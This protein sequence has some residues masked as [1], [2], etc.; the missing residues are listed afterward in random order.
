MKRLILFT[1]LAAA[2]INMMAQDDL[3]FNPKDEPKSEVTECPEGHAPDGVRPVDPWRGGCPRDV[4][5]YNRRGQL[6]SY[7]QKIGTDSLGNDIIQFQAGDGL[8][9]EYTS[10]ADTIYAGSAVYAGDDDYAYSRHMSRWDDWYGPY[11]IYYASRWGW[12]WPYRYGWYGWYDPWY[13]DLYWGWGGYYGW[14]DPWFY[15]YRPYWGYGWGYPG[16]GGHYHH[17]GMAGT[18]NHGIPSRRGTTNTFGNFGGRRSAGS[19]TAGVN[20]VNR[21]GGRTGTQTNGTFGGQR[22]STTTQPS[23]TYTPSRSTSTFGGTRSS[24]SFGGS[25]G[26]SF[27][28]GSRGGGFGGGGSRGGGGSFGGRR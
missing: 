5:E 21:F 18:M 14:Y 1:A 4:D 28:G 27:G 3:Y 16:W 25:H 9:P 10:E 17:G 20:R 15:G 8:Y 22:R 19:S 6:R 24:G 23:R 2:S 26:S 7:Y 11:D 13:A 12:G